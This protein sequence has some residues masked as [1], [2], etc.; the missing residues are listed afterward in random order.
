VIFA[1]YCDSERPVFVDRYDVLQDD[2]HYLNTMQSI[3]ARVC[4]CACV[5]QVPCVTRPWYASASCAATLVG[6][7]T[8]CGSSSTPTTP[9]YAASH[10]EPRVHRSHRSHRGVAR[11]SRGGSPTRRASTYHRRQSRLAAGPVCAWRIV[12]AELGDA[13]RQRSC[14]VLWPAHSLAELHRDRAWQLELPEHT[15]HRGTAARV[16]RPPADA[17]ARHLSGGHHIERHCHTYVRATSCVCG[18]LL[19]PV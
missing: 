6:S 11:G 19:A 3:Y 2:H 9:R 17:T 5:C 13:R 4:V 12:L 1:G 16:L 14:A 15:A 7:S 18:V 8:A 10:I